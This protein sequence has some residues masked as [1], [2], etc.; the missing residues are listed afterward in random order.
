MF[1][2]WSELLCYIAKIAERG[3]ITVTEQNPHT[4]LSIV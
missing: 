2:L 1:W 3:I 4:L